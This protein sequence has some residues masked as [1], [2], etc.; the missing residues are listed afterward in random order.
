MNANFKPTLHRYS[1][2]VTADASK[3]SGTQFLDAIG[4]DSPERRSARQAQMQEQC[5]QAIERG[6]TYGWPPLMVEDCRKVMA[7]RKS[8]GEPVERIEF[9]D[10]GNGHSR[11]GL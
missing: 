10:F 4:F 5:I 2:L 1:G 11:V 6:D 7:E 9:T 3:V 8:R